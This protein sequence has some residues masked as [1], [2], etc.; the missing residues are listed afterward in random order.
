MDELEKAVRGLRRGKAVGETD[1]IPN[2]FIKEAEPIF[3]GKLLEV[4]N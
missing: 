1:Q 3:R 4:L 2:E